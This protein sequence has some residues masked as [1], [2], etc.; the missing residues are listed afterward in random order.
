MFKT[1][2]A[3]NKAKIIHELGFWITLVLGFIASDG[4]HILVA[5]YKGDFSEAVL[6]GL[7]TL[8]TTSIVKAVLVMVFPALFPLYRKDEGILPPKD[9]TS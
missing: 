1:F 3:N 8:I 5:L 4:M 6:S 7:A 9:Q 2:W